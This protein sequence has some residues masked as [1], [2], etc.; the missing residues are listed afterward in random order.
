MARER[1]A[2]PTNMLLELKFE[3]YSL[4]YLETDKWKFDISTIEHHRFKC[5]ISFSGSEISFNIIFTFNATYIGTIQPN[6]CSVSYNQTNKLK[7]IYLY[8]CPTFPMSF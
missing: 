2:M 3:S 6:V 8:T 1:N 5:L 7:R 4:L